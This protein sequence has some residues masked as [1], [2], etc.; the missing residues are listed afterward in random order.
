MQRR[1]IAALIL[2]VA[3]VAACGAVL[4]GG[5]GA[6]PP[7]KARQYLVLAERNATGAAV[8]TAV[9]RSG[10]RIVGANRR[11][12][13]FTV[14]SR[15]PGFARVATATRAIRSAGRSRPIGSSR[16]VDRDRLDR[17][18]RH[19]SV[20]EATRGEDGHRRRRRDP[21]PLADL[22]WDM[23]MINATREGS[24]GEQ[25]GRRKVLV[26]IIDTGIRSEER[27]VGK[28]CRL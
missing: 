28:E 18:S 8:R 10:G 13:L 12:G 15:N 19:R 20:G 16:P 14:V 11:I 21:E 3:A 4:A 2:A 23:R 25:R 1:A 5:A 24:Y 17:I 9:V 7:G 27:R 22:Q 26:G 6:T